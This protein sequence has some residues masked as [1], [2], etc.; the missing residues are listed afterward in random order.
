MSAAAANETIES[1]SNQI[2][3]AINDESPLA[4]YFPHKGR[5]GL[6]YSQLNYKEP[7][8]MKHSGSVYGIK[9]GADIY[10]K[11]NSYI[12]IDAELMGGENQ[13]NGAY[14]DGRPLKENM[15][16]LVGEGRVG[17]GL[18]LLQS[19]NYMLALTGSLGYRL[20]NTDGDHT[21]GFYRRETTYVYLPLGTE[22]RFLIGSH[23]R[24]YIKGEYD[25]FL[26]GTNKTY[27]SDINKNLP[28]QTH[29]Q[30]SG[31]GVRGTIGFS[32]DIS[33]NNEGL[34]ELF[35]QKW[36]VGASDTQ[37]LGYSALDGGY[38]YTQEPKN[39]TEVIGMS[40]GVTF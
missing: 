23:S 36:N 13:Y 22:I 3:T 9:G 1:S 30:S 16:V 2:S 14:W 34:I 31:N 24:L 11:E 18:S 29:K 5:L 39:N 7:G 12:F 35:Y 25:V 33:A 28:D 32:T 15:T 17:A 6:A 10:G 8:L 37:L 19:P 27:L 21:K 20:Y 38:I 4:L 26:G 40:L